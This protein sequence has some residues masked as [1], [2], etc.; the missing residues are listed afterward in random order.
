MINLV[1]GTNFLNVVV[2]AGVVV[3]VVA[4][5]VVVVVVMVVVDVDIVDVLDELV[6]D[7]LFKQHLTRP[8]SQDL[9]IV[10]STLSS[11][12]LEPTK[13]TQSSWTGFLKTEMFLSNL[14]LLLT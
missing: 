5:V 4:G 3:V 2:V 11:G 6:V 10:Y 8:T 7:S 12:H 1:G 9:P 14:I 13:H